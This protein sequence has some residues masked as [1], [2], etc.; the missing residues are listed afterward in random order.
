MSGTAAAARIPSTPL[1]SEPSRPT[2]TSTASAPRESTT[3]TPVILDVRG[4][5]TYFF[6]YDG[7]V[8]AL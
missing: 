8:K 5:R 7:V 1:P 2:Q 4:L 3:E 6:T